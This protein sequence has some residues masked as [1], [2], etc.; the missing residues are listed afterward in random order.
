MRL[1]FERRGETKVYSKVTAVMVEL[2]DKEA[3]IKY[4][5]ES[6]KEDNVNVVYV[7][8]L[9]VHNVIITE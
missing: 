7:D 8:N 1:L 4:I 2:Y 6:D 9:E 3:R 5:C